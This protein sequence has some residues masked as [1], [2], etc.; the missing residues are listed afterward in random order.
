[1][2]A[3]VE[4]VAHWIKLAWWP[5]AA[6]LWPALMFWAT[7]EALKKGHSGVTWGWGL[8]TF[9]IAALWPCMIVAAALTFVFYKIGDLLSY[10]ARLSLPPAAQSPPPSP[11]SKRT[12]E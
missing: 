9:L 12:G 5:V 11:A 3:V 10:L 1:M 2:E 7:R 4:Q 6:V 8:A